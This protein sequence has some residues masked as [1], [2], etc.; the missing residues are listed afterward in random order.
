LVALTVVIEAQRDVTAHRVVRAER[1]FDG[2]VAACSFR[3][4][5]LDVARNGV[6]ITEREV[7]TQVQVVADDA[8][9]FRRSTALAGIVPVVGRIRLLVVIAPSGF[10]ASAS[11]EGRELEIIDFV[12]PSDDE[13]VAASLIQL[14]R[15]HAQGE[16]AC[17]A[18]FHLDSHVVV[19]REVQSCQRREGFVD[20]YGTDVVHAA[21]DDSIVR[22]VLYESQV[23]HVLH[24]TAVRIVSPHGVDALVGV[25]QGDALEVVPY[26]RQ[27]GQAFV[28][29]GPVGQHACQTRENVQRG[30]DVS[31]SGVS[32][33]ESRYHDVGRIL[34]YRTVGR[35]E[36]AL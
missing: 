35:V 2:F 5:S 13:V 10:L 36:L 15:G 28:G 21:R 25:V 17:L 7:E 33:Q 24:P 20:G 27:V 22:S 29:Y 23:A 6:L 16:Y 31:S 18:I 19:Q 26:P 1:G 8:A 9:V 11:E 14:G 4:R 32:G 34:V 12:A 30:V 3:Q